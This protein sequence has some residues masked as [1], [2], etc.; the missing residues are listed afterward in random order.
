MGYPEDA[1]LGIKTETDTPK[2]KEENLGLY[3]PV[4]LS[5]YDCGLLSFLLRE[6]IEKKNCTIAKLIDKLDN[7]KTQI[8]KY[9]EE[10]K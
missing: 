2:I 4:Y 8:D 3:M 9:I 7:A 5:G 6:M 10:D 1:G